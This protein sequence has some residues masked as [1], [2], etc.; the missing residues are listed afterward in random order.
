MEGLY[1]IEPAQILGHYV[2]PGP[3]GGGGLASLDPNDYD[4]QSLNK[5]APDQPNPA[6]VAEND[7]KILEVI[8]RFSSVSQRDLATHSGLS[9]GM[10]N[11]VLKRLVGTGYIQIQNLKNRKMRYFLTPAG[12]AAKYRRAQDYLTRTIRV[13]ETYRQGINKIIQEQ[14]GLGRTQFVIYGKG[15]I[16]DLVKLVLSE[17]NGAVQYRVCP[18]SE[19]VKPGPGEVPLICYLPDKAPLLGI[20]I[21]ETILNAPSETAYA[22]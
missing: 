16:V 18:P 19:E 1:E 11:L 12:I 22:Q 21:L 9:L 14:I 3:C 5:L 2:V 6:S 8:A 17:K 10:V 15:D 20:S 4:V 7:L 13:Y